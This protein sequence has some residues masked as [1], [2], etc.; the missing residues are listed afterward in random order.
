MNGDSRKSRQKMAKNM[1]HFC[2]NRKKITAVHII[3]A[4]LIKLVV[5]KFQLQKNT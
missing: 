2:E 1:A 5:S 3:T 4:N